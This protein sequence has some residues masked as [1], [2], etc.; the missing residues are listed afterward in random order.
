MSKNNLA[1]MLYNEPFVAVFPSLVR[2]LDGD[3]T[4]AAVLQHIFFRTGSYAAVE[5]TDGDLW[6]PVSLTDLAEDIGISIKQAKRAVGKLK[7][8]DFL[9]VQQM[10][11]TDRRNHYRVLTEKGSSMGTKRAHAYDPNGALPCDP[12]G[13]NVL[14]NKK[15]EEVSKNN[16]DMFDE[17]WSVYPRK[18]DKATARKAFDKAITKQDPEQIIY[19]ACL[20]RDDP[21]RVA[22]FTPLPATWL[23]KERWEDEPL[24]TRLDTAADRRNQRTR[25]L[26]QWAA[27]EDQR[28]LEIQS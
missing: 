14:S 18:A 6:Y 2:T 4:T 12:N 15:R 11:G 13:A 22:Q 21:N 10:G 1:G 19:A 5:D 3:V 20:L 28:L 26:L 23:N 16:L 9:D 7:D 25:D 17:F 27:M 8:Q 24:P